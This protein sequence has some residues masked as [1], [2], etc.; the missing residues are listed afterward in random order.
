[1]AGPDSVKVWYLYLFQLQLWGRGRGGYL[2]RVST[3]TLQIHNEIV[4]KAITISAH[5]AI[6]LIE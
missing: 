2:L 6:H 3:I 5:L 4:E 1:M